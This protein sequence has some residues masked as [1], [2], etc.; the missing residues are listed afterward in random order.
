MASTMKI[1]DTRDEQDA[2]EALLEAGKP[3][4]P[5]DARPLHYLL[6][7][8]FRYPPRRGGSR[9]RG[10]NDPG[11][12]YG[13]QGVRT[14]A[15]E[16]GFWRWRFLRDAVGLEALEPVPHTAFRVALDTTAIDLRLPPF[17]ADRPV[18]E[19]PAD[20]RGTQAI[21]TTAREAGVG[22]IVYRSV[23]DPQPAWCVA[24]L[25]PAG[26]ARPKPQG[27][28]QTW[29]LAVTHDG[30]TWRRDREAMHFPQDGAA[31]A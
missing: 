19:H 29:F 18:W 28:M 1:V 31:P 3:P 21:A 30:A 26:F 10:A 5:A 13:A 2:L 24:L 20:Y 9:F 7:T 16:L 25:A 22:A 6:A 27:E 12:F 8:P 17:D 11:V 4:P 15:A 14:A 23:R